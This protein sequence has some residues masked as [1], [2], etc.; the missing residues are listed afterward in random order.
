MPTAQI[1]HGDCLSALGQLADRS[2]DAVIT[3]PPYFLDKLASNWDSEGVKKTTARSQVKSL[4]AGM[5]FDPAQGRALQ[6]FMGDVSRQ[7]MRVLKP[8]GFFLAFSAPRLVHRLAVA[9]EDEGFHIRDQWAWL[10]TQNQVKAMS[11]ARFLAKV[12]LEP[13]ERERI[14]RELAQWKTPQIKSCLEPIVCAQRPPEGTFLANWL[15]HGVGL[16]NTGARVGSE[17]DM[18]PANVLTH[19]PISGDLDRVFL[20]PKPDRAERGAGNGHVSVKP[21]ELMAQLIRLT[22]RPG[23]VVL[24]PFNGSG[25]TGIAALELGCDYIGVEQNPD[26]HRLSMERFTERMP[27]LG[28]WIADGGSEHRAV[29]PTAS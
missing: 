4:P 8:G 24:D 11:V 21:L 9:I 22:C 6:A 2:V 28:P 18:F 3:D 10:Y 17:G 5:K 16:I 7:V 29:L 1:I 27:S 26:Y 23:A 12:D 13:A 14:L 15:K 19:E 20:V 25:S